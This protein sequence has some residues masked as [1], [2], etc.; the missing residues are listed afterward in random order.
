MLGSLNTMQNLYS[1]LCKMQR[2]DIVAEVF[3]FT[4]SENYKGFAFADFFAGRGTL[5]KNYKKYVI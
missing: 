3:E 4:A 2:F 1:K 5:A